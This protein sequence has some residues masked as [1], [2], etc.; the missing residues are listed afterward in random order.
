VYHVELESGVTAGAHGDAAAGEGWWGENRVIAHR[1]KQREETA[2][3]AELRAL[4][5]AE[6]HTVQKLRC[7]DALGLP[8]FFG[9]R[10]NR[11]ADTLPLLREGP[12][13]GEKKN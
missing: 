12:Y 5:P 9:A 2:K 7:H 4:A 11:G 8:L 6:H 1:E 3:R 10:T 13:K